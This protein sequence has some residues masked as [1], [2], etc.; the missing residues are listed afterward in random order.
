MQFWPW[1]VILGLV[2]LI[3]YEPGTRN[4]AK[5][6]D[7]ERVEVDGSTRTTQKHSGPHDA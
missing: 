3:S 2:F 1:L 7:Q 4:L 5:Y 6:F